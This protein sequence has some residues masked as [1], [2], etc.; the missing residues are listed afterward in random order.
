MLIVTQDRRY[1]PMVVYVSAFTCRSSGGPLRFPN[2]WRKVV[3]L[4]RRHVRPPPLTSRMHARVL[5][6]ARGRKGEDRESAVTYVENHISFLSTVSHLL[7]IPTSGAG[8]NFETHPTLRLLWVAGFFNSHNSLS[9]NSALFVSFSFFLRRSPRSLWR[10]AK[11]WR[12][13]HDDS[14]ASHVGNRDVRI[15]LFY[16]QYCN[17]FTMFLSDNNINKII[18]IL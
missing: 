9:H 7:Y 12:S 8:G 10:Y 2:K 5:E 11:G 16:S 18:I 14:T 15:V 17:I 6:L 3:A 1:T 13:R 4:S